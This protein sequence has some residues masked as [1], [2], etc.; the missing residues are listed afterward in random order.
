MIEYVGENTYNND[1][2]NT[3]DDDDYDDDGDNT[4]AIV[5]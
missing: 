2:A 5:E 3:Y 4:G 1:G